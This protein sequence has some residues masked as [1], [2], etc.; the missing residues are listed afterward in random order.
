MDT[1]MFMNRKAPDPKPELCHFYDV[2]A[3]LV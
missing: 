1:A 2:S 3:A